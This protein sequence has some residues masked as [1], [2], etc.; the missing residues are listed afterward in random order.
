MSTAAP[1]AAP[2]PD[3]RPVP[4]SPY[5]GGP[6][7]FSRILRGDLFKLDAL[8]YIQKCATQFGDLL[9]Y[10][11]A[12]FH[13][14]QANHPDLVHDLLITDARR[15]HRGIVMQKARFILGDGLLSS[16][17]P[18]HMRQRRL[19]QPA[20]HR[21]RVAAYG[22]VIGSYAAQLT[23]QWQ[24]G[25][26]RDVY[27]DMQTLSLR[28]VGKTLFDSE[29]E[30]VN[31]RVAE[32][33]D[34]FMSFLPLAFLPASE[35]LLRYPVPLPM[36]TRIRRSQRE[37]D[38]IIREMIE[39]H[40]AEGRDRGDLLSMLLAA[41]DEEEGTGGM[42]D[43]QVKAECITALLAGNETTANGLS[44]ALWLL[45]QHPEAQERLQ[46]E[47]TAALGSREASAADYPHLP[48]AYA[49]F[50][51]AMRLYPPV[52]TLARTAAETYDWRGFT[53]PKGAV[54]MAPQWVIHRDPRFWPEPELFRPQRFLAGSPEKAARHRFAY[55]PFAAGSRQCIGEGLAWMEGVLVLATIA[56]DWTIAPPHGEPRTLVLDPKVTLRPKH[57]VRLL[58][59][60][61]A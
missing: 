13:I 33:V 19:A 2:P 34:A 42:S 5:P 28:I 48:F 60:R 40:R 20:F 4:G 54:L 47:A 31:R 3:L 22:R 56:R 27:A 49:C 12:G 52:W 24:E 8:Q 15:H 6:T 61:R 18:F 7:Y 50:A 37:L 17:D 39:D 32:S 10:K 25:A 45:A 9:H 57:G 26:V 16:E 30:S 44:F 29:L 59:T 55:F 35:L 58:T 23:A 41:Q 46:T 51:E 38:A 53:I 43:E 14:Y 1:P 21:D 36:L 11:A